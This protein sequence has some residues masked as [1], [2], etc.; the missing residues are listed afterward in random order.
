MAR[1]RIYLDELISK[2]KDSSIL[3]SD[4][5]YFTTTD[6]LEKTGV[7][8][9]IDNITPKD[10][11][12]ILEDLGDYVYIFDFK[13]KK[14]RLIAEKGLEIINEGDSNFRLVYAVA[15][16]AFEQSKHEYDSMYR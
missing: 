9:Y 6:M 10:A 14:L 11:V 3:E 7:M 1:K 13:N 8:S 2:I 12:G 5:G 16:N 4:I 15:R